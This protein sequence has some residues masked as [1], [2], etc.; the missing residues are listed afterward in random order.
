MSQYAFFFFQ[1]RYKEP[2]AEY[3]RG[4]S[5]PHKALQSSKTFDI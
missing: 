1:A 4:K 3:L 2:N 5:K